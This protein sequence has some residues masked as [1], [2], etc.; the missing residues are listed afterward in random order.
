MFK[1]IRWLLIFILFSTAVFAGI[2][3][4]IV[5]KVN[6]ADLIWGETNLDKLLITD[7]TRYQELQIA[8]Y[9]PSNEL[10]PNFPEDIYNFDSL[11]NWG[12]EAGGTYLL[13][14]NIISE[15]IETKKNFS[16]PLF[17]HKY[18]TVGILEG[19]WRFIDIGRGK[20]LKA[21]PINIEI[22]G[23][24]VIQAYID[25][26]RYDADLHLSAPE[27]SKFYRKLE[28]A[29]SDHLCDKIRKLTNVRKR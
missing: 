20:L 16:I 27:K 23:P 26:N 29:A 3:K 11:L 9:D 24:R 10:I 7:L 6:S 17:A 25:D 21:E 5:L 1:V 28:K 2:S 13:F 4:N 8:N 19:E 15:R 12:A 22:K 14:V 18:Q